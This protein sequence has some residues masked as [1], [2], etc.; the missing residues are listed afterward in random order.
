MGKDTTPLKV[1]KF[2][3]KLVKTRGKIETR[4]TH[5]HGHQRDNYLTVHTNNKC[6]KK[7]LKIPKGYSVIMHNEMVFLALLCW[8]S[9][10]FE[11]CLLC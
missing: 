8:F 11:A 2:N 10:V 4:S 9:S 7:S 6:T 1:P 3:K 5:V